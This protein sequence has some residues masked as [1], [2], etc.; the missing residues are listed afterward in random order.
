MS[1]VTI[2]RVWTGVEIGFSLWSTSGPEWP[3]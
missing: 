2:R 1:Q 3:G